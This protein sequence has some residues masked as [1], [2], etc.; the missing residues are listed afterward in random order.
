MVSISARMDDRV[1][2]Y[3]GVRF[4]FQE[5]HGRSPLWTNQDIYFVFERITVY[6]ISD[7]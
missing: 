2:R 7:V 4:H 3:L 1:P 6:Y 5:G